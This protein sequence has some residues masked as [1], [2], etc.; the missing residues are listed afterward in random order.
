MDHLETPQQE[1]KRHLLAKKRVYRL[2]EPPLPGRT[3][4]AG[5]DAHKVAGRYLKLPKPKITRKHD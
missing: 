3:P 4:V 1:L 2:P 5:I